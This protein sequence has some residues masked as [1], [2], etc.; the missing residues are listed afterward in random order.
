MNPEWLTEI[1][2]DYPDVDFATK[3]G[4]T[5]L[6]VEEPVEDEYD[7]DAVPEVHHELEIGFAWD[8]SLRFAEA[9]SEN[10]LVGWE[11]TAQHV[12][13]YVRGWCSRH[14]VPAHGTRVRVPQ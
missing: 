9:Y 6:W 14:S 12:P 10:R 3:N 5:R 13:D 7:Y 8:E 2:A 11:T 1:L 4:Q